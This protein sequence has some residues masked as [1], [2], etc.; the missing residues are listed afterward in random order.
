MCHKS[1]LANSFP[2]VNPD[3]RHLFWF[4]FWLKGEFIPKSIRQF[5]PEDTRVVAAERLLLCSGDGC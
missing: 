1:L 5:T 4:L 2:V 3:I